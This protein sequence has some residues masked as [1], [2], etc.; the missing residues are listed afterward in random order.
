MR[1]QLRRVL[2]ELAHWFAL[3]PADLDDMTYG[4]LDVFLAR[5]RKLPPVGGVQMVQMKD[6]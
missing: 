3:K 4:E 2:P 5:L 1:R 6:R